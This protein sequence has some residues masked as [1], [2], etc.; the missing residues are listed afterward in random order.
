LFFSLV[1]A[2]YFL[3][4]VDWFPKKNSDATSIEEEAVLRAQD[5][6]AAPVQAQVEPPPD[7]PASQRVEKTL[8]VSSGD[9]LMELLVKAGL[10]RA[11]AHTLICS[12]EEVF[13]PRRLRRGQEINLTFTE[14]PEQEILFQSLNL[15]LDIATE[16]QVERCDENGFVSMEIVHELETRPVL[17][18]GEIES[19]LYVSAANAGL[20]L[21][22]LV[23]MIRAYS[24]DIDFQRD[25][26]PGDEFSVV[27]QEESN[28]RDQVARGGALL[29]ASLTTGGRALRI[30][31]YETAD[32][33]IDFFD[34]EGKSVGK[35][36]MITPIDGA[37]LSSG[38]GKRRHPIL[39]YSRMHRGLDFAAPTGTPIMAAGDGVVESATRKGNYGNYIRIRHP[40][41]YYT[42]YAH[43][44]RFGK[45]VRRGTRV[46]QGQTIGY[47]GSTGLSTGPHLHYE[48][49]HRGKHV[50]PASLDFPPTRVLA[51]QELEGFK[52]AKQELDTLF[53]SLQGGDRLA[54]SRD[55]N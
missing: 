18:E 3:V 43:L 47:V 30:Y 54:M 46:K 38:Y 10:A 12:L 4:G 53:A 48:V 36:L 9:T 40:N 41:E 34:A 7:D 14:S 6:D 22:I 31:R 37:R 25:I 26:Q 23:Q 35:T 44:S 51:G 28:Q 24:F 19:S 21:E 52:T 13:D 16:V 1:L 15:K 20:P 33:E 17:V 8:S 5:E 2:G 49:H 29:Y 55:M 39:G 11:E 45:G 27:Y 50:N 42:V 32:G